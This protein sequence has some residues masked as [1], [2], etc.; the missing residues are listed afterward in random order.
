M[1]GVSNSKILVVCV[2]GRVPEGLA[3]LTTPQKLSADPTC[4]V[5]RNQQTVLLVS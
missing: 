2:K 3:L 4:E 5:R 1:H